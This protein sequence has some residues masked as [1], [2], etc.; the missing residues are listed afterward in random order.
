MVDAG[1]V[2]SSCPS[3]R[4]CVRVWGRPFLRL[5]NTIFRKPFGEFHQICNFYAFGNNDE[6][7]RFW[8]QKVE[9]WGHDQYATRPNTVAE[10]FRRRRP[11]LH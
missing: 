10:T 11:V 9:G 8:G 6:L 4:A 1:I 7:I 2:F 5:V 3:I